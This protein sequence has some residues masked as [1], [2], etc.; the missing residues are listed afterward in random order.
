MSSWLGTAA[1]SGGLVVTPLW[2]TLLFVVACVA[3]HQYRRVW[4][5]GGP[6]WQAWLFGL[7]AGAC[8][9]TL[10]LVPLRLTGS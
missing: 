8:L 4:K 5:A 6:A 9:L 3:G 10:G 1:G 2:A 7:L